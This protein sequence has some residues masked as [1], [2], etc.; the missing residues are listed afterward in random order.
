MYSWSMAQI[1]TRHSIIGKHWEKRSF[2]SIFEIW[3]ISYFK[4]IL[5][6]LFLPNWSHTLSIIRSIILS[7]KPV[8]SGEWPKVNNFAEKWP[9]AQLPKKATLVLYPP[10]LMYHISSFVERALFL[11]IDNNEWTAIH[12]K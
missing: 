1:Q 10:L 8:S 6:A 3:L 7:L 2:G 4:F 5:L 9:V 12:K 11:V